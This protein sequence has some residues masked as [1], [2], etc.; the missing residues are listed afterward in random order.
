MAPR[1][2]PYAYRVPASR[3]CPAGVFQNVSANYLQVACGEGSEPDDIDSDEANETRR[4]SWTRE[5]KL[6]AV[7]YTTLTYVAS[8]D[9]G[10]EL[11]S[12][13]AAAN[14]IGC[15]PKML[16]SWINDYDKIK[17]SPKGSRK[18][19]CSQ[20]A[21]EPQMESQLYDLFIEKRSIG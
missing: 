14:D 8:K 11:I 15:T 2:N 12:R 3:V 9:G 18:T 4:R 13:N 5:Q 17:A 16:R 7:N 21:K 19:G 10:Q 6:G 1:H 20:P